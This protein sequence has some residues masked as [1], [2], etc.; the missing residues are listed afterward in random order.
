MLM[1]AHG[2]KVH[3]GV[4]IH[5]LLVIV[6]EVIAMATRTLRKWCL[7]ARMDL[8]LPSSRTIPFQCQYLVLLKGSI[9]IVGMEHSSQFHFRMDMG[10]FHILLI[11]ALQRE[12]STAYWTLC[13]CQTSQETMCCAGDGTVSKVRKFGLIAQ[14]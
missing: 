5:S 13:V 9:W 7:T 4:E 14:M 3:N 1:L 12:V 11:Q 8:R 2:Q 6:I 10:I